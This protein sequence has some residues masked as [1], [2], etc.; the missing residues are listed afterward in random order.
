MANVQPYEYNFEIETIIKQFV[1]LLN[2]AIVMRYD[3]DE[4]TNERH[5][6]QSISPSYVCGPKQRIIYDLVNK[7]KNYTLPCII[8]SLTG[9]SYDAA[10]VSAKFTPRDRIVEQTRLSYKFPTPVTFN[11]DVTIYAKYL[12]DLYQLY[13]KLC[14]Q[15]RDNVV[16]S[17]YVPY[18]N[19][20]SSQY[21]ELTSKVVWNGDFSI[22]IKMEKRESDEDKFTGKLTFKIDGWIFQDM[23]SCNGNIILDIGTTNFV[24]DYL[25]KEIYNISSFKPLVK[26]VMEDKNLAAYN[27]PREWNNAHPRIVNI[28]KTIEINQKYVYFLLDKPRA[29]RP[30]KNN[31]N[32]KLTFDGYNFLYADVLFVPSDI[33]GIKTDLDKIIYDYSDEK[34]FPK[35]NELSRK[36]D[37]I[38]G[39]KMKVLEQSNNK[40]TV[41][42]SGI[43][44]VGNFD[45]VVADNVDYDSLSDKLGTTL[46]FEP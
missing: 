35:R 15:F 11:F 33:N 5:L 24:P 2:G 40:I 25:N 18:K 46:S 4:K 22:D 37:I 12:T 1:S 8:V 23:L 31:K 9:I 43:D 32:L 30:C 42:F 19:I 45:V 39:Y 20:A 21:E 29:N 6:K 14:T 17:W 41:D 28:F 38:K 3:V 44:Y 13:G 7:A 26:D 34:T 27:N 36:R 10:R 16:F